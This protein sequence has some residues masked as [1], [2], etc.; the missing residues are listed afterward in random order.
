[1]HDST[2]HRVRGW[3]LCRR[4]TPFCI[5]YLLQAVEKKPAWP[6]LLLPDYLFCSCSVLCLF[7]FR[8]SCFPIFWVSSCKGTWAALSCSGR[9]RYEYFLWQWSCCIWTR[10]YID[11]CLGCEYAKMRTDVVVQYSVSQQCTWRCEH[12]VTQTEHKQAPGMR[13]DRE[14][15]LRLKLLKWHVWAIMALNRIERR[16]YGWGRT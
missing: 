16:T 6:M 2:Q 4:P 10:A 11:A 9:K 14:R 13:A 1:M 8:H 15:W 7:C 12:E 3:L 5:K